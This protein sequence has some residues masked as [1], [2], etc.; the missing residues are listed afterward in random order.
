MAESGVKLL[1][2][3]PVEV[4]TP[5]TALPLPAVEGVSA[6]KTVIVQALSTNEEP[7]VVGDSKVKAKAGAHGSAEQQGIELAAKATVAF[8]INDTAQIF[9]DARKAKDGVSVTVLIA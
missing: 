1:T 5:G 3:K 4:V 2:L 9:V 6:A 8:E 7:V